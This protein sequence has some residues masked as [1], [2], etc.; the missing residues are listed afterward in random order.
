MVAGGYVS[1]CATRSAVDSP[2]TPWVWGRGY[3]RP[4]SGTRPERNR[5]SAVRR[6]RLGVV[7]GV[8]TGRGPGSALLRERRLRCRA[9]AISMFEAASKISR[10]LHASPHSTRSRSALEAEPEVG[11]DAAAHQENSSGVVGRRRGPFRSRQ[12][13]NRCLV[14]RVPRPWR[15]QCQARARGW[16]S[17]RCRP[18]RS[19]P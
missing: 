12:R 15:K 16:P 14:D 10:R 17:R 5:C 4:G 7:V 3:P 6:R 1:P 18:S 11:G 8:D 19:D 2:A 9:G 13:R